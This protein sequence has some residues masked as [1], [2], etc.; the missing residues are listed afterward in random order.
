MKCKKLIIYS[1]FNLWIAQSIIY[2]QCLGLK[3]NAGPD[4]FTCDPT[5][6]IQLMG[7]FNGTPTKYFWTPTT[8]LS[9]P[10]ATD[11]FVNAPPGKYTYTFNVEAISN[12]NLIVNGNFESGNTAFTHDYIYSNPG[13]PFGPGYISVTAS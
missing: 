9:D 7:S 13:G 12:T 1:L 2:S 6:P 4:Q 11:P 10:N 3:A 8:Y 5:M